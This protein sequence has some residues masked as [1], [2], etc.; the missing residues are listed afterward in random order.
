M[1]KYI[2]ICFTFFCFFTKA[3]VI[4]IAPGKI[5]PDIKLLNIDDK[6]VSFNDYPSAKG[7]IVVFTCNTCPYSKAYE[8]RII[9]LN[10]K[11]AALGFPV[12]AINPNDPEASPGDNFAKMK[13]RAKS[14]KYNFPYLYDKG[15]AVTTL[16]GAK[17][18]PHVFIVSKTA[19]GNII[20]YTGAIDNDTPN[21]NP[22]KTRYV[23]EALSALLNNKKPAITVTKAIG[24]RVSWK[25]DKQG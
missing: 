17:N 8:Q 6:L 16:Y 18:T 15:Q 11:Y 20:E 5:A 2:T 19:Q 22:G 7:F 12:I 24:C 1:K 13:Q 3:Q 25:K 23:E 10:N 4:T 14:S 9:E 21:T